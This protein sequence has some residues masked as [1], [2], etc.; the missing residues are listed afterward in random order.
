[1]AKLKS[2]TELAKQGS[3]LR[4]P[5]FKVL[6]VFATSVLALSGFAWWRSDTVALESA[7]SLLARAYTERRTL[8]LRIPGAQY[9][10]TRLERGPSE[11]GLSRPTSL[12]EAELLVSRRLKKNASDPRW[13]QARARVDLL[14]GN[15]EASIRSLHEA[16]ESQP[17]SPQLMADLASGY[18]EQAQATETPVD[19]GNAVEYLGEALARVP[20]DPVI[21][22]N[23]ALA[24]EKIF[25]YT[26]AIA[27]WE[28][29]LQLDA[30]SG[31]S[32]EARQHLDDDRGK[33]R[34]LQQRISEPALAASDVATTNYEHPG[35]PAKI[36]ERIEEYLHA[37]IVSWLPAAYG[38][39]ISGSNRERTALAILARLTAEKH[40]D[41]WLH[42]LL[43]ASSGSDFPAAVERL[44]EALQ[45]NDQGNTD[46]ARQYA[47]EADHLFASAHNMAGALRSRVEY[48]FAAHVEQNGRDCSQAAAT[49]RSLEQTRYHWLRIQ[50]ELEQGTCFWFLNDLEAARH[51]YETAALQAQNHNYWAIYLRTQD[52][53][54]GLEG[55][56]GA[57]PA[58]WKRI[59]SALARFWSGPYP[60][61][62][63][64]NLY[65]RLL[66]SAR[67]RKQPHLQVAAW[68]VGLSLTSSFNDDTLRGM[69]HAVMAHAQVAAGQPTVAEQEFESAARLLARDPL[70]RTTRA[71]RL[72]AE[73]RL[74]E[75]EI[76][77]GE[78]AKHEHHLEDATRHLE[79]AVR[80]LE[81]IQ[82]DVAQFSDDFLSALFYANLGEVEDELNRDRA[83][84]ALRSAVGFAEADLQSL[85]DE[86]SRL[87]WSQRSSSAYRR[88]IQ[89]RLRHSDA[90]GALEIWEWYRGAALRTRSQT[91]A[92]VAMQG[93]RHGRE[94]RAGA[95][96]PATPAFPDL[97]EVQAQLPKLT[98]ET[99]VSYARLPDGFVAWVYDN[100]G[101]V[102]VNLE[103]PPEDI[104]ARARKFQRLCSQR[105]SR[106]ADVRQ[107][108]SELFE[109]ILAPVESMLSP[110]RT[111]VI[112][113][114]SALVGV[115]F[116]A[117]LDKQHRYLADR[118]RVISSLGIYYRARLRPSVV[119]S[120]DS[121]AVVAAVPNPGST[122]PE[123]LSLPPLPEANRE[124]QMVARNF[125]SPR[126]VLDAGATLKAVRP[127]LARSAVFHF[128]GHAIASERRSGL[129][130]PDGTLSSDALNQSDLQGMQLAVLSAC[131]TIGRTDGVDYDP[132]SLVRVFASAGV[133]HF[134]ASWWHVDSSATQEFMGLFYSKLLA[135]ETVSGA[136][137]QAKTTLRQRPGMDHPYYWSGFTEFGIN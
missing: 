103:R 105:D 56:M 99:V 78:A 41:T 90:L 136:L 120:S 34:L 44:S 18:Y 7:K 104:E 61:M 21:L 92:G 65:F 77:L 81:N 98:E 112:E 72:E 108:G 4:S 53:L 76:G 54:A 8:D 91:S 123:G 113:A 58:S 111:I 43:S 93:I 64:Y 22:F 67:M 119:I 71:A 10:P 114:D 124:A 28:R 40:Q 128:A 15:Y 68:G 69:A 66:E 36:D 129:L 23:R 131:E 137:Q 96:F 118:F 94:T 62:R 11:S 102:R 121:P 73:T 6:G 45:A 95:A 70:R 20:D 35:L 52:H 100:R 12:I 13:L 125:R 25:L 115:P 126:L 48:V 2:K 17:D 37:A 63:G 89:R 133:P 50:F 46:A 75:V 19:Y 135:G 132:A 82:G 117:L 101:V 84:S 110:Q 86:G 42:D 14:N 88:L 74:A 29:Y 122:T 130:F 85:K 80:R 79:E 127:L 9:G 26:Q 109:L 30:Q 16:L 57:F 134:V 31:W 106:P 33:M 116:D 38:H 87:E 97:N 24:C 51:R 39:G 83:D 55:N 59:H 1:M 60:A 49:A 3:V 27:D 32:E 47:A 107:A 5:V